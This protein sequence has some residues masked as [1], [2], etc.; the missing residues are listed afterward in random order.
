MLFS[1][2][3]SPE[4]CLSLCVYTHLCDVSDIA[5]GKLEAKDIDILR[6]GRKR[7]Y[8]AVTAS[9]AHEICI[10]HYDETIGIGRDNADETRR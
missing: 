5:R 10:K 9:C 4:P 7:D 8:K 1:V 6:T 2:Q 3:F